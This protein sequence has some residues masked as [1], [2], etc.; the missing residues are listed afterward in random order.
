MIRHSTVEGVESYDA[1][2][3]SELT[4]WTVAVAAPVGSIEAPA[5]R[6]V[7]LAA[8]GMLL[9]AFAA[10]GVAF[11]FGRRLVAAIKLAS[12]AAILLGE[13]GKP[14]VM[15]SSIVEL[16]DL[17]KL[18]TLSAAEP[19]SEIEFDL[20]ALGLAH[21]NRSVVHLVFSHHLGEAPK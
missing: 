21:L 20:R 6:A 16:Q 10:L 17:V 7:Q 11:L 18:V 4:G 3:H 15:R 1:F 5:Y 14:P 13:G 9:A 12:D 19:L 2:T 8:A